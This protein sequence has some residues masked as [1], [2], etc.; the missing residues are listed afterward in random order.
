MPPAARAQVEGRRMFV[1]HALTGE[2]TLCSPAGFLLY[3][4]SSV[5]WGVPMRLLEKR[6]STSLHSVATCRF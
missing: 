5:G 3:G 4:A 1:N 6:P 2:A